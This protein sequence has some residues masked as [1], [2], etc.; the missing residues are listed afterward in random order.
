M[1]N[2]TDLTAVSIMRSGCALADAFRRVTPGSK[3]GKILIQRDE[4]DPEKRA[5]LFYS[6][7]PSSI[8]SGT[9]VVTDPMVATGGSM[10]CALKVLVDAGVKEENIVVLCVVACPEGIKRVVEAY[11]QLKIIAGAI[12]SHLNEHKYIVPGL[13][14]YGDRYYGTN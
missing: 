9:V 6:K 10:I 1:P 2:F 7:L 5:K 3:V 12:D 13:G 11:P 8:A 14:D 4:E